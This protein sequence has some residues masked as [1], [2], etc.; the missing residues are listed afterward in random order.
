MSK[1]QT[2]MLQVSK[3]K[4]IPSE[5]GQKMPA[6]GPE[7]PSKGKLLQEAKPQ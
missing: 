7:Q 3:E 1:T 5:N 6:V 4:T 2:E